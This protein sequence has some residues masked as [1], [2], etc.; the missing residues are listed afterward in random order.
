MLHTKFISSGPCFQRR[1]F[2]VYKSIETCDPW[3]GARLDQRGLIGG[4]YVG[5]H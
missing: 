4:I 1:I 5:D 2:K 3:D